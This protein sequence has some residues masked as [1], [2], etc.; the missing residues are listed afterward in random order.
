MRVKILSIAEDD[1]E[2][3][4]RFYELQADGLGSYFSGYAL[5]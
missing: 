5:L 4:Y 2:E 3:G 1:L